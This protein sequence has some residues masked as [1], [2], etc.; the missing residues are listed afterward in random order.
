ML[1]INITM[2]F[3][4]MNF[5]IA[6]YVLNILLIRPIR[7]IIRERKGKMDGLLGEAEA[8]NRESGERLSS[9]EAALLKARHDAGGIRSAARNDALAEQQR[10]V[11]KAGSSAQE[12][13]AE[14]QRSIRADADEAL[15]VLRKQVKDISGRA[16]AKMLG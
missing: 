12:Y 13:L 16:I 14:A 15:A 6:L 3:Q 4:L 10:I 9:Y 8:F 2:L 11:A 1:D 7:A 5:F